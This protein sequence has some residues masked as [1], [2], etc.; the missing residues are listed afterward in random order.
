MAGSGRG[1]QLPLV[2][3][4]LQARRSEPRRRRRERHARRGSPAGAL[5]RAQQR[6]EQL[7]AG[8]PART[9]GALRNGGEVRG[10]EGVRQLPGDHRLR[11]DPPLRAGG[12]GRGLR[13]RDLLG[14]RL[15]AEVPQHVPLERPGRVGDVGVL[16]EQRQQPS[17]PDGGPREDGRDAVQALELLGP[18]TVAS[19]APPGRGRARPAAPGR[20]P[21]TS[22]ARPASRGRAGQPPRPHG[23]F[24]RAPRRRRRGGGRRCFR[25]AV[26]RAPVWRWPGRA[27]DSSS[28]TPRHG[29]RGSM[30]HS[31]ADRARTSRAE[32]LALRTPSRP[33]DLRKIDAA[34]LQAPRTRNR[35]WVGC[36]HGT[37]RVVVG[38]PVRFSGTSIISTRARPDDSQPRRAVDPGAARSAPG[39]L[40]SDRRSRVV[41]REVDQTRPPR[42]CRDR[43]RRATSWRRRTR[44]RW[45]R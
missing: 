16:G 38:R 45:R 35:R 4:Q 18:M 42:T 27:T 33:A 25:G 30:P 13:R 40:C 21:G 32:G 26:R 20:R 14:R 24:G 8:Q 39:P 17:V 43:V 31:P 11:H 1:D 23:R 10:E 37:G 9:G 41:G 2:R 6:A 19:G 28:G 15:D 3:H 44:P 29:G 36:D 7:P 5:E 34:G 12:S 22:C